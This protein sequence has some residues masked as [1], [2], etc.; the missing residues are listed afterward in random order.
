M[1]SRATL[2][3]RLSVFLLLPISARLDAATVKGVILANEVGGPPVANVQVS[4][5]GG[6]NAVASLSDGTFVLEFPDKQPGETVQLLVQ[7]PGMGG[8]NDFHVGL[9]F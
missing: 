1:K 2:W 5:V 7:K 6:A 3:L 8:V 4:A 9:I